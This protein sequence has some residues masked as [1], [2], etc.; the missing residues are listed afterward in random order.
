MKWLKKIGVDKPFLFVSALAALI[1]LALSIGCG[2]IPKFTADD[3]VAKDFEAQ[4]VALCY[5]LEDAKAV[6]STF[7]TAQSPQ[8]FYSVFQDLMD[9]KRCFTGWMPIKTVKERIMAGVNVPQNSVGWIDEALLY[10]RAPH[11]YLLW[12]VSITDVGPGI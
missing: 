7:T 10:Q 9:Q 5:E 6:L 11:V 3:H 1:V 12:S 2:T 8:E 4:D